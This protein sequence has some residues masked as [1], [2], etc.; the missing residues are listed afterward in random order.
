MN[1]LER[2]AARLAWKRMEGKMPDKVKRWVPLLGTAVLVTS[3]V[4]QLL[5]YGD[6]ARQILGIAGAVGVS[7]QSA[8]PLGE[9]AAAGAAL[10]G[11]VLKILAQVKKAREAKTTVNPSGLK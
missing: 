10:S 5:G 4:L 6:V 2:L 8:V 7:D 11:V 3:V 1:V 9:L